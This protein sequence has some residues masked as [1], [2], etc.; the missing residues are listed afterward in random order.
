L[1]LGA[2]AVVNKKGPTVNLMNAIRRVHEGMRWLDPSL[3]AELAAP[4]RPRR[5]SASGWSRRSATAGPPGRSHLTSREREVASLV[6]QGHR[7]KEVAQQLRI[8][9]HTLKNHVRNIY[10]KL[11]VRT[12]VQ[13][14]LYGAENQL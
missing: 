6:A 8:S 2:R 14:A 5:G 12:R 10:D 4:L 3:R 9:E 11:N 13:L 1:Q 7:Y